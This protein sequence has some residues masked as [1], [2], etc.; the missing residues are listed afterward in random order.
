[1]KK[2][3]I[4]VWVNQDQL[5]KLSRT[6]GVDTAKTIRACMNCADNVIHNLFGGEVKDVFRRKKKNE[7]L[8]FYE[9][10]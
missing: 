5:K 7:E 2:I 10:P 8:D 9:N 4:S 3:K 6:L 1:M